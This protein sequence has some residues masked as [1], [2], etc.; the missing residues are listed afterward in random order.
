MKA[1]ILA[2]GKGVRINGVTGGTP[3]CLLQVGSLTLIERQIQTLRSLGIRHIVIVVGCGA[4]LVQATCGND[5][6]YVTNDRF[7]TTNSLYSLW[8]SREHLTGGFVVLNADVLFDP[9][10]LTLLL[11][12][13]HEDALLFEPRTIL[14]PPLGDEEMKVRLRND[15]LI[16]IAKSIDPA[17]ADGENVGIAKFGKHGAELLIEQMDLILTSGRNNAWAPQAFQEFALRRPL[18]A[19]PTQGHPWIEIDF[20]EDYQKACSEILPRMMQQ[21]KDQAD[22][23]EASNDL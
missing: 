2:A 14:S 10:L 22:T 6:E 1:I 4:D 18:V 21:T 12:S 15:L 8:L 3:K 11:T 7:E 5:C 16:E 17:T 13:P 23:I 9:A 19:I 20:V